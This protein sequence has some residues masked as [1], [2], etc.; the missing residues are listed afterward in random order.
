[1][2]G[3]LSAAQLAVFRRDGVLAI[4]NVFP[5]SQIEN[6][7]RQFDEHSSFLQREHPPTQEGGVSDG[8]GDPL[9]GHPI[10]PSATWPTH[11]TDF[12]YF[13][14]QPHPDETPLLRQIIDQL[15]GSG[16]L[17]VG[18]PVHGEAWYGDVRGV[19][20]EPEGTQWVP[21]GELSGHI[22]GYGGANSWR[23]GFQLGCTFYLNEVRERGGGLWV[24]PRSHAAVHDYFR[25]HEGAI[26][27]RYAC[28]PMYT[29]GAWRSLCG[30]SLTRDAYEFLGQ[31]GTLLLW[32]AW[33]VHSPS[34]NCR[35]DEPRIAVHL[36]YYDEQMRGGLVRH[37]M[38]GLPGDP[39]PG[40]LDPNAPGPEQQAQQPRYLVGAAV[41]PWQYWGAALANTTTASAEA[42]L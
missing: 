2:V 38:S 21:P 23:G 33:T 6:W 32:H 31:P 16:R 34:L 9:H 11:P 15:G 25:Q 14:L 26:D 13:F 28:E 7:Q 22:D 3:P 19:F 17:S 10:K 29:E 12:P 8:G 39:G 41:D 5:P 24:W 18:K 36:R 4:H 35:P 27:G 30:D 37:G 40:T 42:R 1:M 20:P